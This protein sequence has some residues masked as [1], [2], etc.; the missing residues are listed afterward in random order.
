[1][2][3]DTPGTACSGNPRA[4]SDIVARERRCE[5]RSHFLVT[6]T[7]SFALVVASDSSTPR[8]RAH[9]REV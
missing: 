6:L 5:Q 9:S 8:L 3:E 2:E 1:M 7:L 4:T